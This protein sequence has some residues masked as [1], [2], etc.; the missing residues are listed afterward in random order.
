MNII[1]AIK[2]LW[3][4]QLTSID[5]SKPACY[6]GQQDVYD[7]AVNSDD[8]W[9]LADN[10]LTH[11]TEYTIANKVKIPVDEAKKLFTLH[12]QKF[13]AIKAWQ[14][15]VKQ[16][17]L[18]KG[19]VTTQ[20]G[21]ELK[22]RHWVKSRNS[23][24]RDYGFR[25]AWNQVQAYGGFAVRLAHIKMFNTVFRE[26]NGQNT[27][28]GTPLGKWFGKGLKP[29]L[30]LHDE[31]VVSCPK[32]Y[33]TEFMTDFYYLLKSTTLPNWDVP[34]IPE[35]E[36]ATRYG[37]VVPLKVVEGPNNTIILKVKAEDEKHEIDQEPISE[38]CEEELDDFAGIEY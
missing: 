24:V 26:P 21:W 18:F 9:Y 27:M 6:L 22:V 10:I 17:A 2:L 36:V 15:K 34:L 3:Q 4:Y 35:L 14:D 1:K 33:A 8:H 16:E 32:K 7:V 37:L 13:P 29:V 11:N 30:T 28:S 5:Y 31:I 25:R 38:I 23:R 12:Q 19:M 20:F